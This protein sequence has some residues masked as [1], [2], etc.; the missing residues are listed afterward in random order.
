LNGA[1]ARVA[2]VVLGELARSPRMLRHA[3]ALAARG[4]AVRL[5]G[6]GTPP[7]KMARIEVSSLHPLARTADGRAPWLFALAAGMRMGLL[8]F[9]LLAKLLRARPSLVLAQNPPSFPTLLASW[10]AGRLC[11]SRLCWDWHNYGYAML[12]LRVAPT[13]RLVRMAERYERWAGRLADAHLCVS[14]AMRVDLKARFGIAAAV[15]YDRPASFAGGEH[16][17]PRDRLILVCP[18]G[19]T[20]DEDMGLLLEALALLASHPRKCAL[21]VH[22]TGDG[23]ARGSLEDRIGEL[24]RQGLRIEAEYLPEGDYRALLAR[25]DLGVCLHRSTSGVDLPMKVSDLFAA[26]VPVCALDYG[27]VIQEQVRNGATG[28]LFH[29][30]RELSEIVGRLMDDP[31]PLEPMRQSIAREWNETWDM[32][33]QR[34]AAPVLRA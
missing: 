34:C 8:F 5:I 16:V 30:A 33:W 25:A 15:L 26:R 17:E 19:W 2:V 20:A 24:R 21:E 32:A 6:Y 10:M 13:H 23:P 9:E 27:A 14:A 18:S 28:F 7:V 12:G 3:E 29:S 11:G 4:H 1:P 22:L 31:A